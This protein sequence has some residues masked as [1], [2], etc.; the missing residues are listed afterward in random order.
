M[1]KLV[2]IA[3]LFAAAL[4]VAPAYAQESGDLYG[5]PIAENDW[6]GFYAGVMGT[7]VT[8]GGDTFAAFGPV[9]GINAGFD[10]VVAGAEVAVVGYNDGGDLNLQAQFLVRGGALLSDEILVYGAGGVGAELSSGN[11]S[12]GLF[13]GGVEVA[14]SE[15]LSFRGQYLYG[16]ELNGGADQSQVSLGTVFNF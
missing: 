6:S 12:F 3:I 13:G 14:F 9:A 11:E 8:Q 4:A 15:S 10:F 2:P 5:D 7:L 1:A 16:N